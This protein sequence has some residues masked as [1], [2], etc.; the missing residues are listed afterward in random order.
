MSSQAGVAQARTGQ[1]SWPL[2]AG[3]V[4]PL[5]DAY[6]PRHETGPG[7]AGGIAPGDTVALVTAADAGAELLGEFGGTGKTQ[8]AVALVHALRE[9]RALDLM[10]WVHAASRDAVITA[11][12]QTILEVRG[13]RQGE[14]PEAAA[15]A[16]LAW[17][18]ETDRDWLVVFD[19]LTEPGVLAGLWPGGPRGRVLVTAPRAGALTHADSPRIV[20]VG[21]FSR[22]EALA[23]LSARLHADPGQLAGAVELADELGFLPIALGQAGA[24][25][26]ETGLS[27]GQY[28]AE[29]RRQ[30]RPADAP[31]PAVASTWSLAA[32]LAG[33][34]P[35]TGL[36]R[37]ALAMAAMLD[38]NGI[39][40]AVL[41]SR[42][43]CA[44]LSR[45]LGAGPVEEAEARAAMY[46]LAR[47][48]LVT[49]DATS[50]ARTVRIHALVQAMVLQRLAAAEFDEAARAAADALLE[51]W[52]R[53]D[54]PPSFEQALRDCT[55]R[56]R[57]RAG[58]LLWAP[59]CHPVLLRAGQSLESGAL[60][61]PA[62]DY[63]HSMLGA[64]QQFLGAGH[65]QTILARDR[66][67]RAYEEAGR[68]GDAIALHEHAL[69]ERERALS[70]GH[71][72]TLATRASLARAYRAAGRSQDAIRLGERTLSDAEH[73]M[74]SRHPD[75]LTA[76]ND[77]AE[78]YLGAG[79]TNEAISAFQHTL[80]GR[81][82]VLGPEHP[83]TVAARASL[84]HA[85]R[86][87]GRPGDAL[88]LYQRALADGERAHGPE[89]PD[90]IAARAGLAAAYRAAGRLKDAI[91]VYLRTLA[92]R[93]RVLGPEHADTIATRASLADV[94]CATNRFKEAIPLY[95][96]ALA[97]RE[98]ALGPEH[99]ATI[100]TR[101]NLASAYHSAGKLAQAIPLYELAL[102][103]C[104][105][106]QGRDHPDTLTLRS[107]LAQAY[108]TAGRMT[109]ALAI[110]SRT[111]A[112]C[113]R[114]L[115][116]DHPMTQAARENLQAVSP[117]G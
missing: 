86:A 6:I 40:G 54:A 55:A 36:A 27:C 92:D 38:P 76:R 74:G 44:Y 24:M 102:A 112:D 37:P 90:T 16:F 77:L 106:A 47:A 64:S 22:R 67:A 105:R 2:L 115:G 11:Y 49:I 83:A 71:P 103:Q 97:D 45:S 79:R 23:Q 65:S 30:R 42:A 3:P 89:H 20:E 85:Y 48:G 57:Q 41:I 60:T 81:E 91:P 101:G 93:S 68:P 108:H 21:A 111:L 113:E 80:A 117:R 33:E 4:P 72:D 7:A 13:P 52:P 31:P 109:E 95:E 25:M 39:P 62:A 61:G 98:R 94:Y 46:N 66:L 73:A 5:A 104:E 15:S 26:A 10:V 50:P 12:A 28:L 29:L 43:A 78:T 70:A 59:E 87:A 100:A 19:D 96:Q 116:P 53:R 107:N 84:A 9:A 58:L 69:A 110:F 75:T 51:A 114:T 56:L 99:P 82:Q 35:P 18:A 32:E 8:A 17:L 34:M 88:P 14:A 63:W 1:V